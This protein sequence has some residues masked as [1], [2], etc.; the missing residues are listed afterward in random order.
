MKHLV[1]F[2][3]QLWIVV[4]LS[5]QILQRYCTNYFLNVFSCGRSYE[6]KIVVASL[7][8]HRPTILKEIIN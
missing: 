8:S 1:N 6:H 3:V 4:D 2:F 7:R 5:W